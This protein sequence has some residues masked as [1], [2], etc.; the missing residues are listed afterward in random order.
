MSLLK[1]SHENN[2]SI[3]FLYVKDNKVENDHYLVKW[4]AWQFLSVVGLFGTFFNIFLLYVFYSE[5]KMMTTSVNA[6][7]IMDTVYRLIYCII[8]IQWRTYNMVQNQTL[9]EGWM[10]RDQVGQS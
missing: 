1:V 8:C 5:R 7:I 10:D 2:H 9:F 4:K 3:D 6:M